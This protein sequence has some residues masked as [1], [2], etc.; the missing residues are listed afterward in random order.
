MRCP[1]FGYI[2][3]AVTSSRQLRVTEPVQGSDEEILEAE[4]RKL[5]SKEIATGN[6]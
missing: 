5:G 6:S 2:S 4:A 1:F 3:E